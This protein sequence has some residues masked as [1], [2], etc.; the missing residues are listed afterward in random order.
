MMVA[1]KREDKTIKEKEQGLQKDVDPRQALLPKPIEQEIDKFIK[2]KKITN[3]V[4]AELKEKI[5]NICVLKYERSE[6]HGPLPPPAILMEYEKIIPGM[7]VELWAEIREEGKADRWN[8]KAQIFSCFSGQI[9]GGLLAAGG[10]YVGYTLVIRG[11]NWTG[12]AAMFTGLAV[13]I[14]S[15]CGKYFIKK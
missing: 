15:I 3:D 5:A 9:I 13:I 1:D 7:G 8:K 10:L 14:A 12:A 4:A 6:F 11:F 2:K